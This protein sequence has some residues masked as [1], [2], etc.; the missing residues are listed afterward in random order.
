MPATIMP[1]FG[2]FPEEGS[3]IGRLLAGYGELEFELCRCVAAI[4]DNMDAAI[5]A[6][7]RVRGEEKRIKPGFPG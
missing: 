2:R 4:N 6:M 5:K 1:C 3:I 7:F